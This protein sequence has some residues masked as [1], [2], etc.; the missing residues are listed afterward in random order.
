MVVED[1]YAMRLRRLGG[2]AIEELFAVERQLAFANQRK[3]ELEQETRALQSTLKYA[4]LRGTA[5]QVIIAE[6]ISVS[7]VCE[8][9][10]GE[11]EVFSRWQGNIRYRCLKCRQLQ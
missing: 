7:L 5:Q 8:R 10:N 3:V 6:P 9:C 1:K 11:L 2:K 4:K